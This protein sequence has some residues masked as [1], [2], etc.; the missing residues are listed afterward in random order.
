MQIESQLQL[1][2]FRKISIKITSRQ[3]LHVLFMKKPVKQFLV[4][5]IWLVSICVELWSK[6]SYRLLT[7]SKRENLQKQLQQLQSI[8]KY[9]QTKNK[10]ANAKHTSTENIFSSLPTLTKLHYKI[11]TSNASR[12]NEE[13]NAFFCNE[14]E[15]LVEAIPKIKP[16]KK[17]CKVDWISTILL[18][19]RFITYCT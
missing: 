15:K 6:L 10:N 19:F 8:I 17:T 7:R 4:Q 2:F 14:I 16:K 1:K 11:I 12:Y 9:L 13:R 18:Y 3:Q 5:I